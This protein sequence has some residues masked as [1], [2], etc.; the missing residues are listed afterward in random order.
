MNTAK[1]KDKSP[2]LTASRKG[3]AAIEYIL[4]LGAIIVLVAGITFFLK[5][6]VVK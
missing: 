4:L 2:K 6:N 3:Q 5:T 1:V